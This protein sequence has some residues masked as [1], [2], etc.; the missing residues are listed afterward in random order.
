MF[1]NRVKYFEKAAYLGDWHKDYRFS[2]KALRK[3]YACGAD[4]AWHSGDFGFFRLNDG[5]IDELNK[6]AVANDSILFVSEGNHE[7]H[8]LLLS[9]PMNELGFRLIASNIWHVPRGHTWEMNG[10]VFAGFGGAYSID[11]AERT[12]GIDIFHE[13]TITAGDVYRFD[14]AFSASGFD[15]VDVMV[16]H[17]V[18]AGVNVPTDRENWFP[19]EDVRKSNDNRQLL[20]EVVE[21]GK[22][23]HLFHGHYHVRYD[24]EFVLDGGEV[25][26]VH[27]LD[28]NGKG[29]LGKNIVL[30]DRDEHLK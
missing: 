13:E 7:N 3:C 1:L 20:R 23:R 2:Q 14:N 16:T 26:N 17:D 15:R 28:M 19:A 25:V 18:P 21:I 27:G 11:A 24:E 12:Y 6:I 4:F 8:P 30:M 9:L 5:Y 29:L 10:V 22:P